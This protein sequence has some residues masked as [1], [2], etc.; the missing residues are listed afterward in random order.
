MCESLLCKSFH[1]LT[2]R[3]T[4]SQRK[5]QRLTEAKSHIDIVLASPPTTS[6]RPSWSSFTERM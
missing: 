6:V 4:Q 5:A 2:Y 1:L 3:V